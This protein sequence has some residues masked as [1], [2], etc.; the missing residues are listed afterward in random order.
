MY[1]RHRHQEFH[2]ILTVIEPPYPVE[3]HLRLFP[4]RARHLQD[5]CAS[6]PLPSSPTD[7]PRTLPISPPPRSPNSAPTSKSGSTPG[8]IQRPPAR[9]GRS[10]SQRRAAGAGSGTAA[11]SPWCRRSRWARRMTGW[12]GIFRAWSRPRAR[13]RS[14]LAP[15]Q[16]SDGQIPCI[17]SRLRH[18]DSCRIADRRSSATP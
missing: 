10:T 8:A 9:G 6:Y 16:Q 14:G 12:H 4:G 11:R 15:E 7:Q 18:S 17:A 13:Q 3:L 5:I 2:R 1:P